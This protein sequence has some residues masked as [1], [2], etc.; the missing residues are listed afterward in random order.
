MSE[1]MERHDISKMIG[2]PP[3]YVGYDEAG[4]LTERIRRKPY[5]VV[6]LDEIEK[7]H[8]EVFN[9]L[10]QVL[11]DGRLTDAKGRVVSFKNVILIMTSNVGSEIIVN[12]SS[13]GFSKD[14]KTK[15]KKDLH[16][17]VT[18]AL[19]EHFKPEFLNRVDEVVVFDYLDK[20]EIKQIVDLELSKVEKR[21]DKKEIKISVSAKAK[22][23]L[24]DQ[25]YDMSLG[26]RPL[27]RVIQQKILNPLA[28]KIVIGEIKEG[29]KVI[30]D[31]KNNDIVIGELSKRK[32]VKAK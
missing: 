29:D 28:L 27:K 13:L 1:Y 12:E 15:N 18:N 14:A 7:A 19:K 3:G 4:Q 26:A 24:A 32:L 21:L 9:I 23:I 31:G 6:L 22:D 16:E 2:S 20:K 8:P 11:E 30:I 25:G 10:L 5:A 17:K